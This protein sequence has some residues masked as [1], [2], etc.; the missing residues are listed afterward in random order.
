MVDMW[1]KYGAYHHNSVNIGIHMMC[2]P[3]ILFSSFAMATNSG[4]LIPIP[5]TLTIPYLES[6]LATIAALT[7]GGLYVLLE[8][9]AGT[10]LALLCLAAAAGANA[11][12]AVNPGLTTKVAFVV[13]VVAWIFQFIGHGKFE[14]RAPALLD[15][16]V[17]AIFLAPL[18][19]WLELL[20][21]FGYRRE[22]Q[23]RVDK[24]VQKEIAKF[25]A[26]KANGSQKNGK[27]Q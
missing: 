25:R 16:L 13:H 3:I 2:V 5:K 7:W 18:F 15:N 23:D 27:A 12:H 10:L 22:L 11:A 19:V 14:G 9:V 17:Q 1:N 20:F 21:K 6:N 8:P 24:A 26:Q 4:I